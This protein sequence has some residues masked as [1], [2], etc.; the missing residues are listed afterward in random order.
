MSFV[1]QLHWDPA[2]PLLALL[3]ELL[4]SLPAACALHDKL[5]AEGGTWRHICH[6][7]I[8]GI[9]VTGLLTLYTG[10]L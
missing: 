1:Q 5:G 4:F 8:P 7:P 3:S 10:P 6:A 9:V 2:E